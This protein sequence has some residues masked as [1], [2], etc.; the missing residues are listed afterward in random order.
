MSLMVWLPLDGHTENYG[1]TDTVITNHGAVV[2][3]AGKIGKCYTF[4]GN[5][6]YIGLVGQK[7]F[8]CFKGGTTPISITMWVYHADTRRAILF[9]DWSTS[10]GIGVNIELD[11]GHGVRFYWNGSPDYY[12]GMNVGQ[13][14]WH[15]IAFTYDGT[16]LTSYLDG[17]QKATRTGALA[18]RS[19]TA[20]E[21]RLGRDN[22]TTDT[23]LNGRLN[24]FRVYN[25][26]LSAAEVHEIAQGLVLHY[27]LDTIGKGSFGNPNLAIGTNTA[28]TS[29]NTWGISMQVGDKTNTIEYDGNIPVVAITRGSTEQSGWYY[30]Y[31]SNINRNAI[32]VST[33][34]TIAFDVKA[35]VN[36][37]IGLTGLLNGNATNY[38][39]NSTTT[40]QNTVTANRWCHIVFQCRTKDS[41]SDITVS[42]QV[43]YMSTSGSLH[44]TG[45]KMSFKNLKLE[46]GT[47]ETAWCPATSEIAIDYSGIQDSSG[48]GRNGT[49]NGTLSLTS[50]TPRYSASTKF[51]LGS[52]I[53]HPQLFTMYHA[54]YS[55]WVKEPSFTTYG[56][57]Y[58][59]T[60]SPS[61]GTTPWFSANTENS[62]VWAY[63]GGNSP[64]YTKGSG[65]LSTNTWY[66]CA[67]VWN[68]GVAQWYLNG[69]ATG[70]SATY[71][72]KTYIQ[73]TTTGSLG[74]SYTGTSWSGTPFNG[75]LSDFRIYCTALS[76]ADVKALYEVGAKVDNKGNWHTYE[77][78][79]SG[80]ITQITKTGITRTNEVYDDKKFNHTAQIIK[81]NS[82]VLIS[83]NLDIVTTKSTSTKIGG[84]SSLPGSTLLTLKGKTLRFSYEVNA[85]GARY[86]TEQ[87]QTAWNY[88]RYGIHGAVSVDGSTNYPFADN[89]NYSGADKRVEMT[90]TVPNASSFGELGFSI[91]NFDKPASTN[92]NTWYIRNPKLEVLD[93]TSEEVSAT[94]LIEF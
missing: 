84:M 8:N 31:Y 79:E 32:K 12:P 33:T 81:S 35:S 24:D 9:G 66:H 46:E 25:H 94:N 1:A 44:A 62:S 83:G 15:H 93:G 61:N 86:S 88:T 36:G 53:T 17:V 56:A 7:L 41:F 74:D 75:Q 43:I 19:K 18:E 54:T 49:I 59:P 70:N 76:A 71:T 16:T 13:N 92:N 40:I 38:M 65:S 50:D 29:T 82:A 52:Y 51:S 64:N 90:W 77:F 45:V 21:F 22:R 37:S 91:Q 89:L 57:I 4:N 87:G 72:G 63:F 14:T 11:G 68:N 34:Y 67:Y 28:S 47:V 5:D 27:K 6:Q 69:V 2:S 30:L 39:T 42:G 3:D 60:G 58:S 85:L 48:Y 20:G 55:F 23:A 78:V 10:N 26:C 80:L 73:N